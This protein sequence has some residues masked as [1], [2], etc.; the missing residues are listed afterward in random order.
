MSE[1]PY[2]T[3]VPSTLRVAD[4]VGSSL[5]ASSTTGTPGAPVANMTCIS[6]CPRPVRPRWTP[7]G[8]RP[9][10]GVSSGGGGGTGSD[11][12][13]EP[14]DDEPLDDERDDDCGGGGTRTA[15]R[16]S[17]TRN[18][19]S[20]ATMIASVGMRRRHL[21]L[22]GPSSSWP[23]PRAKPRLPPPTAAPSLLDDDDRASCGRGRDDVWAPAPSL[24][25]SSWRRGV[26]A[27]NSPSLSAG[28]MYW[29]SDI[30][31]A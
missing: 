24:S 8:D 18:A 21:L 17:T 19:T 2:V 9:S 14:L 23:A 29:L 26:R 30:I 22:S 1:A 27:P 3:D 13:D 15:A 7:L 4:A 5:L 10:R 20:V 28:S 12:F 16:K 11:E 25:S 6:D 31:I